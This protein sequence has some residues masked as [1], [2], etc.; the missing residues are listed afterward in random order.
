MSRPANR[1]TREEAARVLP[2]LRRLKRRGNKLHAELTVVDGIKF[3][4]KKEADRYEELKLLKAAGEVK[5]FI[6]QPR[7]DLPGGTVAVFDFLIV[8][9]DQPTT[10]FTP[11]R[12]LRINIGT[13]G[14]RPGNVSVE[15]VKGKDTAAGIRNRK[16]VEAIHGVKVELR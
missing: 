6:R 5:W 8:W 11:G 3:P 2:N 14:L 9:Q 1:L 10:V 15:D 16:Q 13:L 4:S 12:S 7:F